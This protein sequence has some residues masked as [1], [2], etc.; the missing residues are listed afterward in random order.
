MK[1]HF[2]CKAR[3]GGLGGFAMTILAGLGFMTLIVHIWMV[4]L[5][6]PFFPPV[7][8][9]ISNLAMFELYDVFFLLSPYW[10]VMIFLI[11]GWWLLRNKRLR[12]EVNND[13]WI[14]TTIL[15]GREKYY[16]VHD[17]DYYRVATRY[18]SNSNRV[19]GFTITIHMKDKQIIWL[20]DWDEGISDL[21]DYLI[22]NNVK[23]KANIV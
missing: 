6:Q 8:K 21:V 1:A 15:T 2:V 9:L 18:V 13:K 5:G 7:N 3:G 14:Y 22:E 10:G 11:P 23:R 19:I 4:S 17:V 20:S 16:T 12:L